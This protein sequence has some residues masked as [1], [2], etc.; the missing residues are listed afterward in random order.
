MKKLLYLL[1]FGLANTFSSQASAQGVNNVGGAGS[2]PRMSI[3]GSDLE[4]ALMAVQQNRV[5]LLDE[6]LKQAMGNV[7]AK[8]DRIAA[9]NTQLNAMTTQLDA[10]TLAMGKTTDPTT[11]AKLNTTYPTTIAKLDA[12]IKDITAQIAA[13]SNTQQMDML[14]LQSLS[15]KRNEAFDVMTNFMKK[16]ADSRP[17]I[18]SEELAG[19]RPGINSV[20]PPGTPPVRQPNSQQIMAIG[21]A[22]APAPAPAPAAAPAPAPAPAPV[23]AAAAAAA[24]AAFPVLWVPAANGVVPAN[25]IIGGNETG[26]TLPV[27]RARYNQGVHPGK[28]VGKNCNFST[29]GKEVLAPQ[30]EVLVGN[31]AALTQNP[32]LVR[33]I[34]AQGGQ[35]PT[36]AFSGG[37]EPGRSILPICQ[38]PYQ[39]GV[40]VGKVLGGNCNFGY[41]GREVLS[42]QYAVLV[43]G[44]N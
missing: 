22:P 5:N 37:N 32:Q 25:A 4:S 20:G 15:N 17:G 18:N 27:C 33:W 40:H 7:Q 24:A 19:S 9:L 21:T 10:L 12:Q 34:A 28:V 43:V 29:G 6:Q 13:L 44:R 8:N 23:P 41:G 3:E 31:P 38:A 35:V 30:Y 14:R 2:V 36:G 16:L 39:G 42:P 1:A 11:I 26:R